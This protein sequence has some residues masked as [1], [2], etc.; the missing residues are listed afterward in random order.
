[1]LTGKIFDIR[2][3]TVHDGPGIRTTVFM[4]GCPL[5]CRWCHNP[6][7][8]SSEIELMTTS[9]G[10]RLVG[11][12]ITSSDLAQ[13]L[14]RQKTILEASEGGV[15]FSGGEPLLQAEF[16]IETISK[17]DGLHVLLD[18]SGVGDSRLFAE[19]IRHVDMVYYDI[20]LVDSDLHKMF[21]GGDNKIILQNLATL[22]RSG[23]PFTIRIPLIPGITDTEKNL[24][25]SAQLASS[26][27]NVE[28]IHLLPY[29]EI[30]GAKYSSLGRCWDPPYDETAKVNT[31]V[32]E[33]SKRGLE[34]KIQ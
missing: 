23:V 1:M 30:A 2:E 24:T 7:G 28:A 15:T 6:E 11:E 17:L 33:F 16:L 27:K 32:A 31:S 18:T 10:H 26:L 29:N 20:K 5:G 9:T 14:N 22:D 13:I 12:E 8:Q 25:D 21:T 19:L 4:K 3:F 34:V